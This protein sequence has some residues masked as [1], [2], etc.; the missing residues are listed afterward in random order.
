MISFFIDNISFFVDDSEALELL[1][2]GLELHLPGELWVH[3]QVSVEGVHGSEWAH[4]HSPKAEGS[5]AQGSVAYIKGVAVLIDF[6]NIF[7]L[8]N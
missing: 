7:D 2:L 5:G 4:G 8:G 3:E 6:D 1:E